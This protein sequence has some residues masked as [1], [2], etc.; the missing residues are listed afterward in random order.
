MLDVVIIGAGPAGLSA[1]IEAHKA[2][3]TY[4]VIE[5]GAI[6]QS[7]QK[8]P[9]AMS[10]FSTP[11][12]LEI[13]GIPFPSE[14]MRPTRIDGLE[15]Y[16]KVTEY[17]ELHLNLFERVA[18]VT[19]TAD[20]FE[21]KTVRATYEAR[22]L[23][24]ATG[25]FDNPNL[26]NVPGEDLS[27]VSHY[28]TEPFLYYRQKVAVIGGK[29]SAAIAAL[30]LYR[31]GAFVTLIHRK[32]KMSDGIKY[33]ILPDLENRIKEGAIVAHFSTEVTEIA[34]VS[35]SV[36]NREGNTFLIPNDFVFALIGYHPD[37]AFL[38]SIGVQTDPESMA[39]MHDPATMETNVSGLYI[40]GS[41]AAGRNNNKIFIE[42]GRL[43]G[44]AIIPSILGRR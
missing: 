6:V 12:L 37:V 18:S 43:H 42:N 13:G 36:K 38:K 21:I 3:L 15:Y 20:R 35:I 4:V 32:E 10:F 19:K 27:K 11:E 8:F 14:S 2:G 34:A 7:V 25:Y 29:N 22:N 30:E 33:W 5:K 40:A 28:Y 24:V 39:P 44:K 41:I 31:H 9:T 26:L 23:I 17:F 1:A 16:R